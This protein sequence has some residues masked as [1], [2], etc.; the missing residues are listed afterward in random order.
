MSRNLQTQLASARA[1]NELLSSKIATLELEAKELRETIFDLSLRLT[2]RS[3][4]A[5]KDIFLPSENNSRKTDHCTS[6]F[7]G[8]NEGIA[9]EDATNK[10][11]MKS[12]EL[13]KCGN[14]E[15]VSSTSTLL[16]P[17]STAVHCSTTASADNNVI[18]AANLP[19][20]VVN[21]E[22]ADS[23]SHKIEKISGSSLGV[24]T[25]ND[26][27]SGNNKYQH[28]DEAVHQS[29]SEGE[30]NSNTDISAILKGK[31]VD[32]AALFA[33][34]GFRDRGVEGSTE[35]LPSNEVIGISTK[36]KWNSKVAQNMKNRIKRSDNLQTVCNG[37]GS[38]VDQKAANMISGKDVSA[39][40]TDSSRRR[41]SVL[42]VVSELRGH[43]GAVYAC[44]FSAGGDWLVS[45]GF[46]SKLKIWRCLGINQKR[47]ETE[48]EVA[49]LSGH[50]QLVSTLAIFPSD[51]A[52]VSGS[53]D[54]S[55]RCWD[56]RRAQENVRFDIDGMVHAVA[57]SR[58]LEHPSRNLERL[59]GAELA[60]PPMESN[61][62]IDEIWF[63][64]SPQK[65]E[66]IDAT[67][68]TSCHESVESA[69]IYVG[70]TCP[71]LTVCDVRTGSIVARWPALAPVTSLY[72]Y[73]SGS[74]G[75]RI[76]SAD[77]S[78]AISIWDSRMGRILLRESID[79]VR[80]TGDRGIQQING[81][82]GISHG[83][84]CCRSGD[85][86]N[87]ERNR[88]MARHI[89]C[90]V[91]AP[92]TNA[93]SPL[94][95]TSC[96][97]V[98]VGEF[99]NRGGY[100]TRRTTAQS[101][102]ITSDEQIRNGESSHTDHDGL[103]VAAVCHDNS[104]RLVEQCFYNAVDVISELGLPT[105]ETSAR[106]NKVSDSIDISSRKSFAIKEA[107]HDFSS[108]PGIVLQAKK[109]FR[110]PLL[111]NWPIGAAWWRGPQHK[112]LGKTP[113]V[114]DVSSFD[115]GRSLVLATG[116]AD[117]R[118]YLFD[119]SDQ[120][121]SSITS[122]MMQRHLRQTGFFTPGK[123]LP[124]DS[125][126]FYNEQE[127]SHGGLLQVLSAHTDR[128]YCV[129]WNPLEPCLASGS[130]DGTV[131]LWYPSCFISK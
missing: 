111:R 30:S 4:G 77:A 124:C 85:H 116:S 122:T 10:N 102:F 35:V 110:G 22:N 118:I 21:M 103:F 67:N 69:I 125:L 62:S 14:F 99:Q 45:S 32:D 129:D 126:R 117:G 93:L 13:V 46:D 78:G 130:A 29:I 72:T 101:S 114:G 80:A 76:M 128:V 88:N 20:K 53:Y 68:M 42:R 28:D 91:P 31:V 131:R 48:N 120:R 3:A 44:K 43:Q 107:G 92:M 8:L 113:K 75:N 36:Y 64:E 12:N 121:A 52:V 5:E 23:L 123:S 105:N 84:K 24:T 9:I 66:K 81:N 60:A 90:L 39:P 55:V 47:G 83:S 119:A 17:F 108:L 100:S 106:R 61:T 50:S 40:T 38:R 34:P 74:C 115:W 73:N 87:Y 63:Q 11:S 95:Q 51:E 1:Q 25:S 127:E 16:R 41:H 82:T 49:S 54:R 33:W 65:A 86:I 58:T 71:T 96:K 15:F 109:T 94:Q 112:I 57:V 97:E 7:G 59:R 56:I 89:S 2:E 26:F 6:H 104:I 79:T 18:V 98:A 37:R 70:S 27:F 19:H